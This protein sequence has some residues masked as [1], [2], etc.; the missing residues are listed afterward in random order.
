MANWAF[1]EYAIEGSKEVLQEI[2]QAIL[3]AIGKE[4]CKG[5]KPL[6]AGAS[7]GWEGNILIA[8]GIEWEDRK[9]DGTG[10]YLRGFIHDE[11]WYTNENHSALRFC[12]EEAWGATDL[13]EV[14]EQNLP[15]KVFY[16]V[17]ESG[18]GIYATNDKEGKY[19]PYIFY[20]D[21]CI[22]GDYESEYF[23]TKE[24]AY[25]WLKKITKGKVSTPENIKKFNEEYEEIG[26]DDDN[27]ILFHEF[28]IVD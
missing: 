25:K 14:L 18:E 11:P 16:S 27:Y 8:L 28:N 23:T 15:V 24:D 26:V 5:S 19:F 6:N 17:E 13:D 20:I 1:T 4:E 9:P 12:A 3:V 2:E 10:M 22:A 7:D 21:T